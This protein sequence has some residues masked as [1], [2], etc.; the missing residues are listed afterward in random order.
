MHRSFWLLIIIGLVVTACQSSSE[1][2]PT[3]PLLLTP[4]PSPAAPPLDPTPT[5]PTSGPMS[6]VELAASNLPTI[7]RAS[8]VSLPMIDPFEVEGDLTIAG[9]TT[10]SPLIRQMYQRFSR[11]GYPGV[12]NISS[13]GSDAGLR[14]FC[15]VG[16]VDIALASR[17]ITYDETAAC[18]AIGRTPIEFYVGTDAIAIVTSAQNDFVEDVTL[19]ELA[20]IFSAERWSQVNPDWPDEPVEHFIPSGD[21]GTFDLFVEQVLAGN[22]TPLLYESTAEGSRD[23]NLL[24]QNLALSDYGIG[25]FGYSFYQQSADTL[26]LLAVEGVEPNAFTVGRGNYPLSRSLFMYADPEIIVN[27][28]QVAAF[29]NFVL[30]YV[31]EE[32]EQVGYFLGKPSIL[33]QSKNNLLQVQ[34]GSIV[35][36]GSSTVYPLALAMSERFVEETRHPGLIQIESIGSGGGFRRFCEEGTTDISNAS[37]RIRD[38]EV[39]ACIN[40]GR[41]PIP[42]RVGTDALAVVTNIENGFVS[43]VTLEELAVIF[44]AERWSDVNPTWPDQ[45]IDRFIP[46]EDSGT[47]DF[48]VETVFDEDAELLLNAPNTELSAD[49]DFLA[50]NV[51]NDPYA[52]GFFG[53]AFYQTRTDILRI[54]AI[55][56]VEPSIS[57]V[58]SGDYAL[59][60]PL[61]MYSDPITIAEKPQVAAFLNF[62]LTHVNEEIEQV[63]YFPSSEQALLGAQSNLFRAMGATVEA[64]WDALNW[65]EMTEREQALWNVLGWNEGNWDGDEAIPASETK[66]WSELTSE[67]QQAAEHLGYTRTSWNPE[68]R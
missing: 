32:I 12:I 28:P 54:L 10:V 57:A 33:D 17:R 9:S 23:P 65:A 58:E 1:A 60:R 8:E 3:E 63:G 29:I 2:L 13:I 52:I 30:T 47:F 26:K 50:Q 51:V 24:A 55:D 34:E 37:R 59:A 19:A 41:N 22:P 45:P 36:A 14:A 7:Q 46:D 64:Y 40:I 44:T 15:E 61:Y 20:T 16:D 43:D 42:F 4:T 18:A 49:D 68:R 27:K 56:G 53:Y 66:A 25:F 6:A 21:S 48:F 35:V 11:E 38:E 62:T 39:T 31:N 5:P 67:E